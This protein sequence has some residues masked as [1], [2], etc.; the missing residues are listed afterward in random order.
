MLKSRGLL[1][2]VVPVISILIAGQLAGCARYAPD[3]PPDTSTVSVEDAAEQLKIT[4]KDRNLSCEQI[5]DE[6]QAIA[7]NRSINEENIRKN[8]TQNQVA[9]YFGALFLIPLIAVNHDSTAK[10]ILDALQFRGDQLDFLSRQKN[11]T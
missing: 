4:E 5:A 7:K 1:K 10:E 9:G 11:C 2:I 8:R 3:L 6:K